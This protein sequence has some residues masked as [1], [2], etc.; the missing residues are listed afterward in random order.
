[1]SRMMK[2]RW[3]AIGAAVAVTLGAGGLFTVQAGAATSVYVP[4]TPTRVLD[5]RP[6]T[7]IGLNGPFVTESPRKLRLTGTIDTSAGDLAVIPVG[8]TSVVFNVTVTNPSAGGYVSVRPG[9]ASGTPETSSVNFA[10]GA[11]VAN[12][13]SVTLPTAGAAA[14][15]VQVFYKGGVSGA[16]TDVLIDIAGYY[17]EGSGTPGPKGEPGSQGDPG[18]RGDAGPRGYSAWD[19]IP[20][21][22]TVSGYLNWNGDQSVA[23]NEL[24]FNTIDFPAVLPSEPTLVSFAPDASS[25]TVDVLHDPTCTGTLT[26]PTAPPG[27]V[28]AY[29]GGSGGI[30]DLEVEPGPNAFAALHTFG[31]RYRNAGAGNGTYLYFSWAYT[32]P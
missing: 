26:A 23:D 6:D 16:T 12:G 1:M 11:T 29:Y 31:L 20:S 25:V 4:V 7:N 21:G 27:K 28:C 30:D 32:A 18:P 2:S 5:T 8:A 10:A 13:G 24:F 3:A 15:H 14:G 17:T 9:D 19:T 22:V